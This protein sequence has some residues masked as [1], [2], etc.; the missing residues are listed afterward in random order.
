MNYPSHFQGISFVM[1]IINVFVR[2]EI[3]AA[4][5]PELMGK[6]LEGEGEEERIVELGADPIN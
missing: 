3:Q 6:E 5:K 2:T 1:I 4:H